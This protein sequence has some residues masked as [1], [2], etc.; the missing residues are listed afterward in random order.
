MASVLSSSRRA[1]HRFLSGA[2]WLSYPEQL[3]SLRHQAASAGT[4]LL[5]PEGVSNKITRLAYGEI[6]A[7]AAQCLV[8][9]LRGCH[10]LV[11]TLARSFDPVFCNL[12]LVR[13]ILCEKA[14]GT[15]PDC[16]VMVVLVVLRRNMLHVLC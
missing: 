16:R 5:S 15:P 4:Q 3:S 12:F 11:L 6:R 8:E 13:A 9:W 1:L 7:R 14:K 2:L 10:P